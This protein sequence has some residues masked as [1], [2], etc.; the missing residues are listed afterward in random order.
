MIG[1]PIN[2]K[3]FLM[4]NFKGIPDMKIRAPFIPFQ[5][6]PQVFICRNPR[7]DK[8]G[9]RGAILGDEFCR[10]VDYYYSI[11]EKTKRS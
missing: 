3:N 11:K 10:V 8:Y 1:K 4:E 7:G 5:N 6:T 2:P 9:I